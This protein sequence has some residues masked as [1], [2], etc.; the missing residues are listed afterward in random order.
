MGIMN[1]G[2]ESLFFYQ[3]GNTAEFLMWD[4]FTYGTVPAEDGGEVWLM[5][6]D[7]CALVL[8]RNAHQLIIA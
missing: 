3:A 7:I 8:R 6:M 2:Y 5:L 1:W 4:I